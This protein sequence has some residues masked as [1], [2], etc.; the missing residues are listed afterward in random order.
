M[1]NISVKPLGYS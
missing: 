1:C